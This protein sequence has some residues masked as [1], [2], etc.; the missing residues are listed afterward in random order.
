MTGSVLKLCDLGEALQQGKNAAREVLQLRDKARKGD[1]ARP[2]VEVKVDKDLCEGCG[3]CHEICICGRVGNVPPG[4]GTS[5]P[6]VWVPI[7]VTAA[8][9]APRPAPTKP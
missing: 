2:L 8:A 5:P 4:K 9:T 6:A 1:L 3:L 7:P